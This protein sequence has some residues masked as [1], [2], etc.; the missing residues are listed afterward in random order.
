MA[1]LSWINSRG[2][3]ELFALPYFRERTFPGRQGRLRSTPLVDSEQSTFESAAKHQHLDIASRYSNSFDNLDIG[4]TWFEGTS[5]E[6]TFTLGI[7]QFGSPVLIPNYHQIRQL[8]LDAQFV[9]GAWLLKSDYYWRE[10]ELNAVS[11]EEDYFA[12]VSGFEYILFNLFNTSLDVSLMFEGLFDSR[13]ENANVAT[14]KDLFSAFRITFNDEEDTTLL[15]GF[16]QD[17]NKSTRN[18]VFEA[19]RRVAENIYLEMESTFFLDIHKLDPQFTLSD[20]S[21]FEIKLLYYY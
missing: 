1:H 15:L 9:T 12:T 20:D 17:L 6:P 19:G 11:L 21:Y 7:D 10:G 8:G 16:F 18:I 5:R 4:L 13:N 2:T 3:F 14:E